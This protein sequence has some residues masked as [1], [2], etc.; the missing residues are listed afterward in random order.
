MTPVVSIIPWWA[1]ENGMLWMSIQHSRPTFAPALVRCR[2]AVLERRFKKSGDS[3]S[4]VSTPPHCAH[5]VFSRKWVHYRLSFLHWVVEMYLQRGERVEVVRTRESRL[6]GKPAQMSC[7]LRVQW[8]TSFSLVETEECQ[9]RR[10][11]C[12]L[13]RNNFLSLKKKKKKKKKNKNNL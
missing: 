10:P 6:P 11:T 4:T 9:H 3:W 5:Q 12:L 2:V 8:T 13:G 1:G 7:C